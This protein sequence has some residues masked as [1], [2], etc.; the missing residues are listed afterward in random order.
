MLI[1]GSNQ[2]IV[3]QKMMAQHLGSAIVAKKNSE[4]DWKKS[5]PIYSGCPS[6]GKIMGSIFEPAKN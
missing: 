2:L 6:P 4:R 3:R 5:T 1:S